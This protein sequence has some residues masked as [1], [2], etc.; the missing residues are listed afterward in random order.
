M[1]RRG[2]GGG[3]GYKTVEANEVLPPQK[4]RVD[5]DRL[6]KDGGRGE[7]GGRPSFISRASLPFPPTLAIPF[8]A[9]RDRV[10][11]A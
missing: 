2:R 8:Q 7:F 10:R 1:G 9:G 6:L 11:H 5:G 3:G 4:R